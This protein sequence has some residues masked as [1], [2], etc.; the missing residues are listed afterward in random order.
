M[1]G[2]AI[3]IALGLSSVQAV[4]NKYTCYSWNAQDVNKVARYAGYK[5]A[6]VDK[7]GRAVLTFPAP[8]TEQSAD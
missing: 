2:L 3:A 5:L 1:D 8:D 4:R 6:I 7:H